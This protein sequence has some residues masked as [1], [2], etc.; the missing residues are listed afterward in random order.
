MS[1]LSNVLPEGTTTPSSSVTSP[2]GSGKV[3]PH[4]LTEILCFGTPL[5]SYIHTHTHT[6]A[7]THTHTCTNTCARTVTHA[8]THT[9]ISNIFREA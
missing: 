8:H 9:K 5:G 2:A 4:P 1:E 3:L 6:H 7:H